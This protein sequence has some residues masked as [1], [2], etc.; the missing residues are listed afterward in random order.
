MKKMTS[1]N[2]KTNP[3]IQFCEWFKVIKKNRKIELPDACCLSTVDSRGNPDG[4]MVLLK[5]FDER[6][7]VFYTNMNSPKGKDL[8]KNKKAA[9]TFYWEKVRRQVRIQGFTELVSTE[10]ADAY[11]GTRPRQAQLGAW[12]S[13]QSEVLSHRSHLIKAFEKFALKFGR[14]K[15]PRPDY[16]TGVRLIPKKIEFWQE[17]SY[18]LHDRFLYTR[19]KKGK[20]KVSRLYP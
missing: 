9:L 18:R 7:F 5:E 6:G 17:R 8:L 14:Q 11:F 4:R 15:V 10:E 20:W 16:W 3:I 19:V 1:K 13:K 12:A 2:L